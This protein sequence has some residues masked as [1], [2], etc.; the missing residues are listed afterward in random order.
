[1]GIEAET[2]GSRPT[3]GGGSAPA[4]A[5]PA[6]CGAT[7][8]GASSGS[9]DWDVMGTNADEAPAGVASSGPSRAPERSAFGDSPSN[10]GLN[11]VPMFDT[12]EPQYTW[13]DGGGRPPAAS[14]IYQ[15][16]LSALADGGASPHVRP[17][18]DS[19]RRAVCLHVCAAL[20]C[21]AH[22]GWHRL[23]G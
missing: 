22:L 4:A 5:T 23:T 1:M 2:H 11:R 13:G 10:Q 12:G 15:A 19:T 6:A 3:G 17:R 21:F 7:H 8:E 14:R 20:C 18:P 9:E 16:V